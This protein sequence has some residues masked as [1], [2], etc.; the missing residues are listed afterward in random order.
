MTEPVGP[1]QCF[2][3][4]GS[5]NAF[6]TNSRGASNAREM[7]KS[8]LFVS[9]GIV[10]SPITRR[11]ARSMRHEDHPVHTE[12]VG[13]HAEAWREK[14]LRQRHRHLPA[15]AESREHSVGIGFAVRGDGQGKAVELWLA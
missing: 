13:E 8:A 15:L 1:N 12:F 5:A 6:Q 2:M 3:C 11:L 7:T 4:S 9:A 14:R 10:L